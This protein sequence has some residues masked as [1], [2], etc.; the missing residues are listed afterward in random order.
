MRQMP[1]AAMVNLQGIAQL[2]ALKAVNE[3]CGMMAYDKWV[4][5]VDS[6]T[7]DLHHHEE[8]ILAGYK[9]CRMF[10]QNNF[11]QLDF[12]L[13]D[14]QSIYTMLFGHKKK[15]NYSFR[16]TTSFEALEELV[17]AYAEVE[18]GDEIA[19]PLLI[20][21]VIS[22]FLYIKPMAGMNLQMA[23]L[24]AFLLFLKN[25]YE[26]VNYNSF[27]KHFFMRGVDHA[28]CFSEPLFTVVDTEQYF[29][30]AD[31]F[32]NALLDCCKEFSNKFISQNGKILSK[33]ERITAILAG[34]TQPLSKA[35]LIS[36]V[37]DASCHYMEETLSTLVK[38]GRISKVG[39]KSNTRYL[40][41]QC[42][43]C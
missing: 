5:R 6:G 9:D 43:A 16:N 29:L 36:C 32:L 15:S 3:G 33:Q 20:S 34:S 12:C 37:P 19:K 1:D 17:Q 42:K 13:D 22:D 30:Y 25:G 2:Q 8:Q 7:S 35:E 14:L 11:S 41:A 10:I 39:T 23:L 27:E 18:H 21:C 24:L 4:E 26:I 31:S 38:A 40:S 28:D